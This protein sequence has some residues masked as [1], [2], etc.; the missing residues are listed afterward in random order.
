MDNAL[1]KAAQGAKERAAEPLAQDV[2]PE[3]VETTNEET[4][5]TESNV[6]E[7]AQE[8]NEQ[9]ANDQES[10]DEEDRNEE[11][12][13]EVSTPE[14]S[15]EE[16]NFE[17][18]FDDEEFGDLTNVESPTEETTTP[19][20][21]PIAEKLGIEA[22]TEDDIIKYVSEL[23]EKAEAPRQEFAN[24]MLAKANEL[25]AAGEDWESY[26][27]L[28][29]LDYTKLSDEEAGVATLQNRGW[30]K[31]RI[32]NM[33]ETDEGKALIEQE[34]YRAKQQAEKQ[35]KQK[36]AQMEQSAE[37]KKAQDAELQ[38]Q[39][40][41]AQQQLNNDLSVEVDNRIKA[42]FHGIK[43]PPTYAEALKQRITTGQGVMGLF[44]DANGQPDVQKIVD[45]V[46]T[47]DLFQN[48]LKR[49]K[50]SSKN[51]GRREVMKD[52]HNTNLEGKPSSNPKGKEVSKGK[53]VAKAITSATKRN[54]FAHKKNR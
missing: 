30:D 3:V 32:S 16:S 39:Q 23:K 5:K 27:G 36:I 24:D 25:A 26:L 6:Q 2:T 48:V 38:E 1:L 37:T 31:E 19:S 41:K 42:G 33:L 18:T 13:E 52:L 40:K 29:T 54:P 22:E 20:Y 11:V 35:R 28:T 44:L 10:R 45:A 46:M 51:E 4:N 17:I 9:E 15:G 34:G 8:V 47:K 50:T 49:A 12:Q 14:S 53:K 43:I 7:Q 21:K